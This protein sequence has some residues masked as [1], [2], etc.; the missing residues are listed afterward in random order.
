MS[1]ACFFHAFE[2]IRNRISFQ[3]MSKS[4]LSLLRD[5]LLFISIYNLKKLLASQLPGYF[6]CGKIQKIG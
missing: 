6:P 4:D 3:K 2:M 1:S 5:V